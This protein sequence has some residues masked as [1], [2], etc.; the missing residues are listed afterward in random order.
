MRLMVCVGL[1]ALGCAGGGFDGGSPEHGQR[2]DVVR[3]V[4]AEMDP[5]SAQAEDTA[6][7]D[8]EPTTENE[9]AMVETAVGGL[10]PKPAQGEPE[11]SE[12]APAAP[13]P[14]TDATPPAPEPPAPGCVMVDGGWVCEAACLPSW[15]VPS[16]VVDGHL[17]GY[18]QDGRQLCGATVSDGCGHTAQL[19]T[20]CPGDDACGGEGAG[21]DGLPD[22]ER[23]IC[24]ECRVDSDP[25]AAA[26]RDDP[27][28]PVVLTGCR[29]FPECV[30]L[31]AQGGDG[32]FRS[33]QFCA[34]VPVALR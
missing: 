4:P 32:R 11:V 15:P 30:T 3:A 17:D 2:T 29:V 13:A 10:S 9:P 1:L 34:S 7:S 22:Q 16:A 26:L 12:T 14:S 20:A 19:A 25:V 6:E 18:T 31:E 27:S 23:F 21:V 5:I 24:A 33:Y 28:R 8:P